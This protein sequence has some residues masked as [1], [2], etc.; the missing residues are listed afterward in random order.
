MLYMRISNTTFLY[1]SNDA[2]T[3]KATI[4]RGKPY[5]HYIRTCISAIRFKVAFD[6]VTTMS[7]SK[8]S[9]II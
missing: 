7:A 3:C 5:A 6:S 9:H 8:Q 1:L 2:H 4:S